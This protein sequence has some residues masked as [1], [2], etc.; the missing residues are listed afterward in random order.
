MLMLIASLAAS[1]ATPPLQRRTSQVER[2][3]EARATIVAAARIDWQKAPRPKRRANGEWARI[4]V[5][6]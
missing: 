1:P 6:E 4:I 5:F 2:M 3:A